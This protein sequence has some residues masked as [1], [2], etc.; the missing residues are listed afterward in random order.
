MIVNKTCAIGS[1]Q[2][3]VISSRD[4][5]TPLR[6]ND[7]KER[8]FVNQLG[9]FIPESELKWA[10][11]IQECFYQGDFQGVLDKLQQN[12]EDITALHGTNYPGFFGIY[13]MKLQ[14]YIGLGNKKMA[15]RC[16]KQAKRLTKDNPERIEKLKVMEFL[17]KQMS[18]NQNMEKKDVKPAR[19]KCSS[20]RCEKVQ[21]HPRQFQTCARCRAVY[22]CSKQCQKNTGMTD[23][24]MNVTKIVSNI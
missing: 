3:F 6:W 5:L 7:T 20:Y 21:S 22:Y 16:L 2:R 4:L 13:D 23:I 17:I 10:F 1:F 14:C 18:I 8:D 11:E 12:E 9:K 15:A 24:G 19:I